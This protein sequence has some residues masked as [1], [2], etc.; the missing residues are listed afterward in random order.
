MQIPSRSGLIIP[1][2]VALAVAPLSTLRAADATVAARRVQAH[3]SFLADD[4]LEGRGSGAR[5]F[6]LAARYVATQ[7][8]RAGLTP[9]ANGGIFEQP[10]HL[11]ETTNEREAGR[12]VVHRD[13]RD[14]ALTP[15]T[16]M[17]VAVTAGQSTDH[18]SAPAVFVGFGVRAP[19][20]AHDDFAGVDLRGKI[21][22]VLSGA[23]KRFPSAQRA[24]HGHVDQKRT[25][26]IQHGAIGMVTIQTPWDEARR[27]WAITAAQTRFPTMRLVDASGAI[28]DGFPALRVNG[29]VNFASAERVLGGAP[30]TVTEIFAAADR[31]E[32]Q[33]FPLPGII[34]LEG[35][36]TNRPAEAANI[37]GWLPGTDPALAGHPVVI[38]GHLDGYGIGTP[39]DGD[40]IYNGAVDN[41]V[42]IGVI[43]HLVDELVAG[44]RL[45]RPIL[46]AAV[47]AEEKGLL[48]AR[49]LAAHP[50]AWVQRYNATINIDMPL[51]SAAASNLV[52][53]GADNST[54][55]AILNRVA[56]R[57]GLVVSPDP[58]PEEV[59]FVRSDQYPFVLQGVPALKVDPGQEAVDAGIDLAAAEQ[60][61]RR[62]RYHKPSDDLSQPIDWNAAGAYAALMLDLVREVADDPIAPTWLPGDFFG[63]T[64]GRG[65]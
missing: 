18:I 28:V 52:A 51:L 5:G 7:F 65:R 17:I 49:Y 9:G 59:R 32:S 48:G 3:A 37:L 46:F 23:P 12:L 54:L 11:L 42:G 29:T 63:E 40:A 21:A 1:L 57:H 34:T 4:L 10:V 58:A 62:N 20:L 43:L 22:V 8:A 45:R 15:V 36:A 13:G 56:S 16:D 41:A 2:L 44:P 24:H 39:V 50:P 6:T 47:T 55:G 14:D 38:T 35:K 33:S 27:P 25:L 31:G 60:S 64:F 19:D 30:K 53:Y 26:L 61:F